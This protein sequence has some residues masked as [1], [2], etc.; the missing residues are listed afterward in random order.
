M[1]KRLW[2]VAAVA[3]LCMPIPAHAQSGD[4]VII[5]TGSRSDRSDS[6]FYDEE[7]SAIGLTR[8]ADYFVKSL[9]VSSDSRDREL[10]NSE[11]LSMLRATI[12]RASQSGITLAAGRY[13]LKTVTLDNYQELQI[14]SGR[15][16]DTSRID[17]YA[18]VPLENASQRAD[19]IDKQIEGFVK[20][21][22][23]TGRS[24]IE[25]GSTSL[26]ISSPDQYRMAVVKTIADEARRYAGLFGSD[27]GIEI[28]GLDSE[29]FWQQASENEVFLYI[30]HNFVIKPK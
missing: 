8:K 10:R 15:R 18:Q 3:T 9:Y 16:P 25:T 30:Q 4:G 11:L 21:I 5:V 27:Y 14:R 29:L 19:D 20:A 26:A 13:E 12:E 23:A 2:M 7:Q 22:P 28:R 1:F 17:I 24:F 6:D